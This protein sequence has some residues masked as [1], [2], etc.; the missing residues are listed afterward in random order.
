MHS[1]KNILPMENETDY[2][3]DANIIFDLIECTLLKSFFEIGLNIQIPQLV[4]SEIKRDDQKQSMTE[5]SINYT[6]ISHTEDDLDEINKLFIV[7]S[8]LSMQDCACLHHAE[9]TTMIL[10]GDDMLKKQP[11]NWDIMFTVSYGYLIFYWT[12]IRYLLKP[13]MKN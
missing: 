12:Q 8:A 10:T 7:H 13:H 11:E 4:L 1:D 6:I 5:I 9:R 3:V 2:I